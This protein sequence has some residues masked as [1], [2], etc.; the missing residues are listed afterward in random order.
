MTNTMAHRGPDNAGLQTYATADYHLGLGHR[1]LSIIDLSESGNQPM[2]MGDYSLV[3]NGEIYNYQ[4]LRETLQEEGCQFRT[5]S[6]TE[7]LLH[8]YAIWGESMVERLVGMFAFALF[9][10]RQQ[11]FYLFR[12][13]AGV[14]PLYYYRKDGLW[15][16][17][18]E[19]KPFHEHPQ[20]HKTLDHQAVALFFQYGYIPAPYTIFEHTRKLEPGHFLRLDLKTGEATCRKYW[21]VVDAYRKP[22]L[23]LSPEAAIEATER[24]LRSAF[25]Y[26][27][28]ADVPVGVLLSGG[29]DST[30]VAAMLQKERTARLKTFTIG[31]E[32]DAFNE[33]SYA[34]EVSGYLDTDHTS[35][36]CTEEEA[37]A[38]IPALPYYYDEPF[39]DPSAIPTTL[40]SRVARQQVKVAL[41]GDGGDEVFAGYHAHGN[42]LKNYKILASIPK[43]FRF[44]LA[45]V[46][47]AIPPENIPYFRSR[48]KFSDHYRKVIDILEGQ[49]SVPFIYKMSHQKLMSPELSN[50]FGQ[51]VAAPASYYDNTD[52]LQGV[53]EDLHKVLAIDY[54]TYL[55]DDLL[56][57]TDRATMSTSLEG[58]DPFLDH[59]LIEFVAQLP[60][61][62]K[63]NGKVKKYLL[64]EVVHRYVPRSIMEREKQGF[65]I[66]LV[67]WFREDLSP[68]FD[69]YFDPARI[70]RQGLFSN[71]Y[72]QNKRSAYR[73]GE[74][75]VFPILWHLLIF[76]MWYERWM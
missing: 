24:R 50:L 54:K 58:R 30:A 51:P 9:D 52:Y 23:D 59:E 34:Q 61:K 48:N 67:H 14:K 40:V 68:L 69:Q 39:G 26:R 56:V 7:V 45:G 41:S 49:V 6:D 74:D 76:Q 35:V 65:D 53:Q 55:A 64:R 5:A 44:P 36:I 10:R 31:F 13:R 43:L 42:V 8:A 28:V 27:M 22:K 66:P 75:D 72:I 25:E 18:S 37:K 33:A 32:F 16:F 70:E 63:I 47:N 2:E 19:L 12:D 73:A 46:M 1:R 60:Q 15:L 57:K 17:A 11:R 20:F 62:Y 21:D 3:F 38:I 71:T 29:Y 4:A